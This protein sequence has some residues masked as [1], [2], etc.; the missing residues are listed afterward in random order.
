VISPLIVSATLPSLGPSSQVAF[1]AA[2][3]LNRTRTPWLI[4]EIRFLTAPN[5]SSVP[6][7]A[8]FEDYVQIAYGNTPITNGYVPIPAICAP[9]DRPEETRDVFWHALGVAHE[10]D[11][12][13]YANM[14]W[15]LDRPLWLPPGEGLRCEVSVRPDA[16]AGTAHS[17]SMV[18]AGRALPEGSPTPTIID[19]PYAAAY[20]T[21]LFDP[22][23]TFQ[24]ESADG[25]LA[26]P[27]DTPIFVD[28]L[29]GRAPHLLIALTEGYVIAN[30]LPTINPFIAAGVRVVD[31]LGNAIIRDTTPF[32][33]SFPFGRRAWSVRTWLPPKSFL[34]LS[35]EGTSTGEGT[36]NMLL[37]LGMQCRREVKR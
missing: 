37:M 3:L 32:A 19:L 30:D 25:D 27:F 7:S 13:A 23:T 35:V 18:L 21:P 16:G 22:K 8:G 28:R 15:E 4:D 33:L 36:N 26:A 5:A 24:F 12:L 2:D 6:G 31:S 20:V 29:I 14:V 11:D 10:E 9:R 17:L 1:N 34:K